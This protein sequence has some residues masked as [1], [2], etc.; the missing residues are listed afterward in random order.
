[1]A[2]TYLTRTVEQLE[3]EKIFTFSAWVKR[4]NVTNNMVKYFA[5]GS[6]NIRINF[7]NH[8]ISGFMI[9]WF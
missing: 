1:M 2:S 3:I 8:E 4:S 6:N 9:T 5:A 7:S